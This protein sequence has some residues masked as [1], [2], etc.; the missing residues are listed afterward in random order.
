MPEQTRYQ[1][2]TDANINEVW[3]KA[4]AAEVVKTN[5][6]GAKCG[7]WILLQ[8]AGSTGFG[9]VTGSRLLW[10][11]QPKEIGFAD[12]LPWDIRIFGDSGEWH[13]WKLGSKWSARFA[14]TIEWDEVHT[15]RQ[16][17]WGSRVRT[18][19]GWHYITEDRGATIQLPTAWRETLAAADIP[20]VLVVRERI[21]R[22]KDTGL[23]AVVDAMLCGIELRNL[24]AK[25]TEQGA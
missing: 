8:G 11:L 2:L 7:A 6:D 19:D 23:A 5:E 24:Q 14:S 12:S 20:L 13:L 3:L 4:R 25:Q 18:E 15:R 16:P 17:L 22:D 10:G 1:D 21:G 9:Y